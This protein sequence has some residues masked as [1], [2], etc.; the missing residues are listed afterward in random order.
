[1]LSTV[2]TPI[3]VIRP[4]TDAEFQAWKHKFIP[5]YAREKVTSGAWAESDAVEQARQE[6]GLLLPG[7]K[8]TKDNYLY[9]VLA[10]QYIQVGV[11]WFAMKDRGSARI[12]CGF[13]HT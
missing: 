12:A 2:I 10:A 8:D 11:L 1:M 13:P 5:W 9:A 4:L 6:F 7:G 3:P